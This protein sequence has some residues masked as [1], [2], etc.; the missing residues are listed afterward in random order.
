M[1]ALDLAVSGGDS[2]VIIKTFQF[3]SFLRYEPQHYATKY[4]KL[5]IHPRNYLVQVVQLVE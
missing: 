5:F 3:L 1:L 4:K 2:T